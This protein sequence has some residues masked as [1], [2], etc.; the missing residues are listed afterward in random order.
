MTKKKESWKKPLGMRAWELSQSLLIIRDGL[1]GI[2]RGEL[3]HLSA[4]AGQLRSLICERKH[5]K[6]LFFEICAQVGVEARLWTSPP[7]P[8]PPTFDGVDSVFVTGGPYARFA[9]NANSLHFSLSD[10][11]SQKVVTLRP[12]YPLRADSSLCGPVGRCPL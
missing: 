2:E 6:S 11:L 4:I 8:S 5:E 10:L 7:A 3:H 9:E 1:A 12:D